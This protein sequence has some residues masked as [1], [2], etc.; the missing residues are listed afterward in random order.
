MPIRSQ[1][2]AAHLMSSRPFG[3]K[4]S[5]DQPSAYTGILA[6][7]KFVMRPP[8][9]KFGNLLRVVTYPDQKLVCR[10]CCAELSTLLH[11]VIDLG[12]GVVAV[13]TDIQDRATIIVWLSF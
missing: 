4:Q 1:T 11:Q 3:F 13:P 6:V 7:Q 8:T 9:L 10:L 2:L 12:S 5:V